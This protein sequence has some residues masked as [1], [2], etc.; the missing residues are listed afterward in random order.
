MQIEI[1]LHIFL[2]VV[3]PPTT[4]TPIPSVIPQVRRVECTQILPLPRGGNDVVFGRPLAQEK[5]IKA[6]LEK[7]I[8]EANRP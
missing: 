1:R 8:T 4:P 5:Q 2:V 7:A 6:V 3:V